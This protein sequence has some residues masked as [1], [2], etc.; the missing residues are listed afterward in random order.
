M[1]KIKLRA[2]NLVVIMEG[3]SCPR[4]HEFKSQCRLQDSHFSVFAGKIVSMFEKTEKD[5]HFWKNN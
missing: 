4:D 5:A 2:K 1:Q 3:D